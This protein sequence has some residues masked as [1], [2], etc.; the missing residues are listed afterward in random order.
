M[1]KNADKAKVTER[2]SSRQFKKHLATLSDD[3]AGGVFTPATIELTSKKPVAKFTY[4]PAC[5]K[6]H[7]PQAAQ[8]QAHSPLPWETGNNDKWVYVEG[9][10]NPIAMLENADDAKLIVASINNAEKLAEALREAIIR[11]DH[12]LDDASGEHSPTYKIAKAAL[13]RWEAQS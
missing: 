3:G 5:A 10:Q 8:P 13:K 2:M 9:Q 1:T 12:L 4:Q 7:E 11:M 6:Q